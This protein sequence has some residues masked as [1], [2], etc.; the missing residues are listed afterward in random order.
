M[1]HVRATFQA[2]DLPVL[3]LTA[4]PKTEAPALAAR[5]IWSAGQSP[6]SRTP[7]YSSSPCMPS[8]NSLAM[9]IWMPHSGCRA[10]MRSMAL[11]AARKSASPA[12][13]AVSRL[14]PSAP[15][16]YMPSATETMSST[17][18]STASSWAARASSMRPSGNSCDQLGTGPSGTV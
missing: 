10:R 1:V 13:P 18:R 16:S 14:M 9:P 8:T 11:R 3:T 6:A 17:A 12:A 2:T 7:S 4:G 5:R 15:A